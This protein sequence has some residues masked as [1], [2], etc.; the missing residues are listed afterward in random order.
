MTSEY[1]IGATELGM[2]TLSSLGIVNPLGGFQEHSQNVDRADA[3]VSGLG[4]STEKWAWLFLSMAHRTILKGYCPS[5]SAEVYIRTI[6]AGNTYASYRV[7]M[8]WQEET[9]R[10]GKVL[11]FSIQF[12]LL[13]EL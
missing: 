2:V 4:W 6:K 12:R 5:K 13:E 1:K 3:L 11:D 9:I 8:I 7:S 10:N